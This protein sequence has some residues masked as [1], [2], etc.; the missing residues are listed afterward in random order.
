ML[1]LSTK[2]NMKPEDVMSKALGF[3]GPGG[4]GL[5]VTERGDT[6]ATFEG[7]GGGV[8]LTVCKEDGK[9]SVDM[10]TTEWENQVKEFARKIKK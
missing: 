5:K 6:C 8:R 3:F 7:G 9:T 4:Y 1:K 10:E 2:T